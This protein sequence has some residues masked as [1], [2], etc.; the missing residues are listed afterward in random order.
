MRLTNDASQ[1]LHVEASCSGIR[2]GIEQPGT[3][4]R[5]S[6]ITLTREESQAVIAVMRELLIAGR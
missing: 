5:K 2:F 1:T 3:E 6:Y 4:H